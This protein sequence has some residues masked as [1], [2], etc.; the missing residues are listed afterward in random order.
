MFVIARNQ[1]YGDLYIAITWL[2]PSVYEL[3]P[4]LM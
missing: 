3:N 2:N 1:I 4:H